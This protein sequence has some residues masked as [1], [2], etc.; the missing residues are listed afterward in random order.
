MCEFFK[1][2]DVVIVGSFLASYD[3]CYVLLNVA[4]H[5][6]SRVLYVHTLF[7]LDPKSLIKSLAKNLSGTSWMI[8]PY[9]LTPFFDT[10]RGRWYYEGKVADLKENKRCTRSVLADGAQPM[11]PWN[12]PRRC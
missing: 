8:R 4:D 3:H 10:C 1:F 12:I 11:G 7:F 2:I 9:L 5:F 6:E